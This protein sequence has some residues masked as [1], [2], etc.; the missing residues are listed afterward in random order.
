[1]AAGEEHV[2]A[3]VGEGAGDRGADRPT[4][5]VDH[6]VLALKQHVRPPTV[7]F[8]MTARSVSK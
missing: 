2:G 3:L 5:P 8:V 4:R 1:M 7:S 6:G